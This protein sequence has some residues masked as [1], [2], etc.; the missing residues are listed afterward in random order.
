MSPVIKK[1]ARM[2]SIFSNLMTRSTRDEFQ[3]RHLTNA[4]VDR[5]MNTFRS[6]D[7]RQLIM[8]LAP[9]MCKALQHWKPW[10]TGREA[11]MRGAHA[12][13]WTQLVVRHDEPRQ[14]ATDCDSDN[15]NTGDAP[16]RR[17]TIALVPSVEGRSQ[18]SAAGNPTRCRRV[19][20]DSAEI[21]H[22]AQ[23]HASE[24]TYLQR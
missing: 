5:R 11:I 18:H 21:S 14:E 19:G 17:V 1:L 3:Q 24:S 16:L 20:T 23:L 13:E 7:L 15:I 22:D 9:D 6:R 8:C 2:T 10:R 4:L 12:P